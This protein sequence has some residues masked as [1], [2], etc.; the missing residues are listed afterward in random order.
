MELQQSSSVVDTLD[1]GVDDISMLSNGEK[2]SF[3]GI[4]LKN[5][6]SIAMQIKLQYVAT[7]Q[8]KL[9]RKTTMAESEKVDSF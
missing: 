8:L 6:S 7:S 5:S 3:F 9:A 1:G 4:W 2:T